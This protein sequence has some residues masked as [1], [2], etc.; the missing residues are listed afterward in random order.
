MKIE[1]YQDA[2]AFAAGTF[3]WPY[4]PTVFDVQTTN[5]V[6]QRD[7]AYAFTYFG[8]TN[9]IKNKQTGIITGHFSGTNKLSNYRALAL[10]FNSNKLKKLYFGTDKFMIVVPQGIKRTNIGGRTNFVDYVATFISP[11][12]IL[13]DNIQKDG[14]ETG[15]TAG[16]TN[17]GNVPTPIEKITGTT[18]AGTVYVEDKDSNGFTFTSP[19][20]ATIMWLVTM[21]DMGSDN[22]ITSYLQV[23]V[24]GVIQSVKSKT[25]SKSMLLNLLASETLNTRFG[26]GASSGFS[27]GP[28]FLFRDGWSGD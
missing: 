15:A 1:N 2:N 14:G 13:F 9:P 12:G 4:N 28:V 24:G 6:D 5:F 18:N 11:F 7:F 3:T 17:E 19:G 27:A 8:V 21:E 26:S 22:Y 25:A 23:T 16:D 20:G 10:H